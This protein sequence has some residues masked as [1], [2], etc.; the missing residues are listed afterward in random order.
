MS[1][2]EII[3]LKTRDCDLFGRWKPSAIMEVMQ[4]TGIAHCESVGLGR[5]VT[6][7]LG[8]VWVLSRCRVE[9][10]RLPVSGERLNIETFALPQK[11]LFFPRAHLFM[12]ADGQ[13]L[14]GAQ[15]WWLLMDVNTRR[16]VRHPDK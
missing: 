12:D 7:R 6:D 5:D 15:G 10:S 14:G 2:T 3:K 9:L 13:R 8:V 4:D 16:I 1:Y 11:H